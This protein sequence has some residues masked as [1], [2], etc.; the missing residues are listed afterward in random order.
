MLQMLEP[1]ML[2]RARS[3]LPPNAACKLTIIS[4]LPVPKATM[5]RPMTSGVTPMRKAM[6]LLPRTRPSAPRA[7]RTRPP[8]IDIT[9]RNI[10][11]SGRKVFRL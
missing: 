3:L 10:A 11:T 2:P 1:T 4:G 9:A 5:V 7:S 6:L 8:R